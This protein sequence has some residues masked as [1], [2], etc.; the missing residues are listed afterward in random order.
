[1]KTITIPGALFFNEE[2]NSFIQTKEV[3]I[4]IEH[5]LHALSKWECKWHSAFFGN[6]KK[7]NEQILDYV[8]CMTLT[9]GVDPNVYRFIPANILEEIG[10]YMEDSMTSIDWN[11]Q[12]KR[13]STKTYGKP[14]QETVT[15]ELIYFWMIDCGIPP[16]YEYWHLNKL[17]SLIKMCYLKRTPPKKMSKNELLSRNASLNAARRKALNTTG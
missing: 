9:E 2:D 14:H 3:T 12:Q 5:S 8:R 11:A 7:T 1:M 15:S 16:E 4:D 6:D 17:L 13:K 10:K